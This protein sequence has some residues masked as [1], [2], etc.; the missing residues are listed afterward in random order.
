[1]GSDKSWFVLFYAPWCGHCKRV[2]PEWFKLGEAVA[3][4]NTN[5]ALVDW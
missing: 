3:E 1:M 2:K 5:V 4:S